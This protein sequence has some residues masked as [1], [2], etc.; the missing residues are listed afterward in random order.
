MSSFSCL[1]ASD[2]PE[3]EPRHDRLSPDARSRCMRGIRPKNTKPE[4]AVQR[5]VGEL[6]YRPDLHT[7]GL[8]GKPDLVFPDLR[9]VI[10]VH[11]CYWHLHEGCKYCSLPKTRLDF[12][13]PKLEGNRARDKR[14]VAAL[15]EM[16]WGVLVIWQCELRNDTGT[17]T[18]IRQFLEV[19]NNSR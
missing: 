19:G 4:V 14:N 9:K 2:M 17:V 18:R 16:G 12:W 10:F 11:G 15:H 7:A 1:T 3:V 6:G 8:P 5:I 13:L